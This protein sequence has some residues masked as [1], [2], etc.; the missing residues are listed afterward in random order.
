MATAKELL[1]GLIQALNNLHGLRLAPMAKK[2]DRRSPWYKAVFDLG[3]IIN[4]YARQSRTV[5]AYLDVIKVADILDKSG[6]PD[7]ADQLDNLIKQQ[8]VKELVSLADDIDNA[9]F[10][11]E[12]DSLDTFAKEINDIQPAREGNLSTRYCPDHRGVQV[13]RIDDN[14]YQCPM[15]GKKYDYVNG[16]TNYK[17]QKVPG[18]S[19]SVADPI[20]DTGGI[21]ITTYDS[22]ANVLR[23]MF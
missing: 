23:S 11:Q 4:H 17:G 14:V 18:G 1:D 9:G 19:V 10:H 7:L 21:P 5:E 15:D 22:R 20:G 12:A 8:N 13:F 3:A 2:L 16:Y 6:R